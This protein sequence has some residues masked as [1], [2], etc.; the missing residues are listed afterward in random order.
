MVL[1]LAGL[2]SLLVL[3]F[4][5]CYK[6]NNTKVELKT[7]QKRLHKITTAVEKVIDKDK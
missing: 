2:V 5:E 3:Y 7:T 6:H 1:I 4:I